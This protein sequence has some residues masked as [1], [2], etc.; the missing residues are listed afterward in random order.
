MR[1]FERHC[2][3]REGRGHRLAAAGGAGRGGL[4]RRRHRGGPRSPV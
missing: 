3:G 1:G 2:Q 4:S